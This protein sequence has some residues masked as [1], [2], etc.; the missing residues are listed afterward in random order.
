MPSKPA[1][2]HAL[3]VI[4]ALDFERIAPQHGSII[5]NRKD[6]ERVF[7]HLRGVEHVGIDYL[8]EENKL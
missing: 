1:L 6:A 5:K 7:R 3:N 4:E 2:D 8:I